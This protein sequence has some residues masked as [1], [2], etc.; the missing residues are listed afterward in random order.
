MQCPFSFAQYIC[1]I[2]AGI[3]RLS[4]LRR[5]EIFGKRIWNGVNLGNR[6]INR[7]LDLTV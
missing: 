2:I 7:I 1:Q 4:C 6:I 3:H 5:C